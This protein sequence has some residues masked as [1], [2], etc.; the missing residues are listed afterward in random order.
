MKNNIA[1]V[2]ESKN[3]TQQQLANKLGIQRENLSKL[4]N[5]HIGFSV[6]RLK[7]VAKTLRCGLDVLV[8]TEEDLKDD[9]FFL[10][11]VCQYTIQ[12]L[13]ECSK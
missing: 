10:Q 11:D 12:F 6:K 9:P 3:I 1:K 5:G 4:E 2:R 8:W 13:D 7:E